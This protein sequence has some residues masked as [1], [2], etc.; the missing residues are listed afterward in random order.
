MGRDKAE[1]VL[2][3]E[4]LARRLGRLLGAVASPV[5]E[6]GPGRSGLESIREEPIGA[7]PLVAVVAGAEALASRAALESALVLAC[8]L[9]LLTEEALRAIAT[10][11]ADASVVPVLDGAAQPLCARW[12]A[13]DLGRAAALVAQGER[14]MRALL[15]VTSPVLLDAA[16]LP[17]GPDVLADVDTPEALIALGLVAE[18]VA[19]D[20]SSTDTLG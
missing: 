19:D 6:V 4:T 13:E 7:G 1:L 16:R 12:S 17:N 8:D 11:P 2:G 9:P 3:G 5:L 10:H 14:S 18:N 15:A 20:A